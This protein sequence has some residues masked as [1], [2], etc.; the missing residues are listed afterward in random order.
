VNRREFIT[1]LGGAAT[2]WPLAAHAQQAAALRIGVL[3][4]V[5]ADD[6]EAKA[7]LAEFRDGLALLGWVEGSTIQ[8]DYRFAG[9]IVCTENFLL[10]DYVSESPNVSGDDRSVGHDCLLAL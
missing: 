8:I 7:E 9:A 5:A 1:L 3:M 4:G 10:I 6:A 2:G